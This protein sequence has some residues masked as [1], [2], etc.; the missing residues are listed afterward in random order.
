MYG[1]EH[2]KGQYVVQHEMC[3]EDHVEDAV[4]SARRRA[5]KY[6]SDNIRVLDSQGRE[7]GVYLVEGP[8]EG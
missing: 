7:I 1:I 4:A 3:A 2:R 5:P 8:A 6:G